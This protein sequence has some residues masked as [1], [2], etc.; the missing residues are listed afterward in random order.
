[1]EAGW[2]PVVLQSARNPAVASGAAGYLDASRAIRPLDVPTGVIDR[3]MGDVHPGGN[4]HYLLDPICGMQ[5]ARLIRDKLSELRPD[6]KADFDQR[7]DAFRQKIDEHLVGEQLGQEIQARRHPQ[8]VPAVR[9]RQTG[10]LS[11][12]SERGA[13]C[14]AAGWA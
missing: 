4:P 11:E 2:S 7:Y 9:A 1:M 13:R 6:Q 10:A 8:A 3:S 5:V 12:E 14:W